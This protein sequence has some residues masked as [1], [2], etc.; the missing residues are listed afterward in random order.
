MPFFGVDCAIVG[1]SSIKNLQLLETIQLPFLLVLNHEIYNHQSSI[2]E[3]HIIRYILVLPQKC[4]RSY[5]FS[6]V[7]RGCFIGLVDIKPDDSQEQN[8]M[9]AFTYLKV[10][11]NNCKMSV[12]VNQPYLENDGALPF[13]SG[14]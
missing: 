1:S 7:L 8:R 6:E 9:S 11:R 3:I 4:K 12:S 5:L 2:H 13:V 14:F 10:R